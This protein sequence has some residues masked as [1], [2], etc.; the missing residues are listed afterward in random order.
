MSGFLYEA[1]LVF[2]CPYPSWRSALW[3]LHPSLL[4]PSVA[5]PPCCRS[6][7]EKKLLK[8]KAPR[9]KRISHV[10]V[11]GKRKPRGDASA[12]KRAKVKAPQE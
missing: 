4:W 6:H 8:H 10:K 7:S 3:L 1:C 12:N 9:R 5:I 11:S 2:K